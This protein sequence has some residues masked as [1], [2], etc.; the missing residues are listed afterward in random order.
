MRKPIRIVKPTI[1]AL[2]L[3][4]RGANKVNF[5]VLKNEKTDVSGKI[6]KEESSEEVKLRENFVDIEDV[7]T[8]SIILEELATIATDCKDEKT[9]LSIEEILNCYNEQLPE[10]EVQETEEQ[11]EETEKVTITSAAEYLGEPKGTSV[12]TAEQFLKGE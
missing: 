6:F 1:T 12:I 11:K 7:K 3:V 9:K 10:E 4:K 8:S 2:A 5:S